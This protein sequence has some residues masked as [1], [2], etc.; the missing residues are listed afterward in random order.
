MCVQGIE[1]LFPDS[2]CKLIA[3][4]L[5]PEFLE[6]QDMACLLQNSL[7]KNPQP[8]LVRLDRHYGDHPLSPLLLNHEFQRG[9]CELLPVLLLN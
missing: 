2:K 8:P 1:G 7:L 6:M 9:P 5:E 3:H 4:F